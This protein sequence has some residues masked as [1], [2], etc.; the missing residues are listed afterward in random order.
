MGV[1]WASAATTIT[2]IT[3]PGNNGRAA[4]A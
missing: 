1:E 2:A 3:I 4:S